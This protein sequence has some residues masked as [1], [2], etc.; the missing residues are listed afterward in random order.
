[1][2]SNIPNTALEHNFT[3]TPREIGFDVRGGS[4]GN[5]CSLGIRDK[6][7]EENIYRGSQ[8]GNKKVSAL[9]LILLLNSVLN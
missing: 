4:N 8:V 9:I 2:T 3:P 6:D 5:T 1:M 7:K